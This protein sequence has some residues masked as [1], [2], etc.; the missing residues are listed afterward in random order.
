MV[1]GSGTQCTISSIVL[2]SLPNCVASSMLVCPLGNFLFHRSTMRRLT[3]TLTPYTQHSLRRILIGRVCSNIE[4]FITYCYSSL[5]GA[6]FVVSMV[7]PL[8]HAIYILA[9]LPIFYTDVL[10]LTAPCATTSFVPLLPRHE[11]KNSGQNFLI[12]PR[13]VSFFDMTVT[14][15]CRC[16]VRVL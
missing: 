8:L 9:W 5:D 4:N 15:Y 2:L 10:L 16:V 7:S 3:T 6:V 12:A 1:Q 11:K 14:T 13:I